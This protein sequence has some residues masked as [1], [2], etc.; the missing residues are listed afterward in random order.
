MALNIKSSEADRLAR[1]LARATGETITE[2]VTTAIAERLKRCRRRTP[3]RR[4]LLES[5]QGRLKDYPILEAGSDDDLVG[6][7][8]DGLPT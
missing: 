4:A 7:D 3:G 5:L 6:Y 8:K 1:E 2:A